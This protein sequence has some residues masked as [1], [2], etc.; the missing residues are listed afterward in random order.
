MSISRV[1]VMFGFVAIGILSR[2]LPH[3]PNFTAMNAMILC[4]GTMLGTSSLTFMAAIPTLII[5]DAIFGYHSTI[6]FVYLSYG[7]IAMMGTSLI[8]TRLIPISLLSSLLF[9]IVTNFGSWMTT[10]LFPHTLN[11]LIL[12]YIAALP[13]LSTQIAGDLIYSAVFFGC[14]VAC[15]IPYIN[16]CQKTS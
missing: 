16:Q 9:F 15:T 10:E 6:P 14:Y 13:F 4:L 3:P 12:C 11:G 1:W 2:L 8:G 7:L 5:T